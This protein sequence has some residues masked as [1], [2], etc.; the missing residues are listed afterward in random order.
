[1]TTCSGYG[2]PHR[3]RAAIAGRLEAPVPGYP[4]ADFL[5]SHAD[6]VAV[7]I[8]RFAAGY[9]V[10]AD[11]VEG[12]WEALR[13]SGVAQPGLAFAAW[14]ETVTLGGLL[15]PIVAN[16]PDVGTALAELERFHPLLERDRIALARWPQSASVTLYSPDGGPAHPETVDA[17][18]AVLCRMLRGLA[19]ERALPSQVMLRRAAPARRDDYDVSFGVPIVFSQPAD[20]CRFRADALRVPIDHADPAVRQALVPHAEHR[21]SRR[22]APW[23]AAVSELA[24]TGMF[25]LAKVAGVLAVSPRTLQLRLEDEG[26]SFAT[27]IDG[28][29]RE[30]ALALL[31]EPGLPISAIAAR[32]G[33]ATPSAFTRAFRRWTGLPPSHYRRTA[34]AGPRQQHWHT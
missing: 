18:F 3:Y 6:P 14:V 16:C 22:Q 25:G 26:T 31:A 9:G 27:V 30:R 13:R 10:V 11:P 2:R 19:G 20:S 33:F 15:T 24:A 32:T 34:E 28:V 17:F 29:R 23:S 21:I 5:P 7:Q 4:R 8:A 12:A 1:M